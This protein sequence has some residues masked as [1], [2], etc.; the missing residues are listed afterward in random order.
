[1]IL[2]I[3]P[4]LQSAKA[5]DAP[6]VEWKKTIGGSDFDSAESVIESF[7][8]GYIIIGYTNSYGAGHSD[9]WMIKTDISGEILWNTT[10]GGSGYDYGFSV[11]KTV[12]G[13]Y[14]IAGDKNGDFWLIKIDSSGKKLWDKTY[15]RSHYDRARSVIQTSDSGYAMIGE[16]NDD[17]F[18]V[19]TDSS[20]NML[21]NKTYNRR[22]SDEAYSIVQTADGGY[23]LVGITRPSGMATD[24]W[25]IK[26]DNSGNMLWNK[27]YGDSDWEYAHSLIQTPDEGYA[28]TGYKS[29]DIWLIKTDDSGDILW[30]KTYGGSEWEVAYSIIQTNDGGYALAGRTESYGDGSSDFWLVKIDNSGNMLW[31]KTI[32]GTSE[33]DEARSVI[34]TSDGGYVLAGQAGYSFTSEESETA[35]ILIIKLKGKDLSKDDSGGDSGGGIPGFELTIV[36]YAIII[37][38]FRKR[39][40]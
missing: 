16:S 6:E 20:G 29:R 37:I 39:K 31:N 40:R 26:T 2:C 5:V 32:F 12:D 27:T 24:I 34:E 7:D 4:C 9:L 19:K 30:N 10:F 21:W 1:M 13:G 35:N 18:L 23:A 17:F 11:I 8:G 36:F 28:I 38:L 15:S 25:F 33:R 14:V 3:L 22:Y